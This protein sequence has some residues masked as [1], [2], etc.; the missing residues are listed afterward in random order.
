MTTIFA[1]NNGAAG[2]YFP[3]IVLYGVY[4]CRRSNCRGPAG[5]SVSVEESHNH[6]GFAAAMTGFSFL[7]LH[8]DEPVSR[9]TP[10]GTNKDY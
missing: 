1:V 5:G 7:K 10:E 9:L 4:N 8:S 2:D 3:G 6:A